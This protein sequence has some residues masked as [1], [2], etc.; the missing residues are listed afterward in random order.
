MVHYRSLFK[1]LLE[2]DGEEEQA[3]ESTPMEGVR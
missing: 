2:S 3:R 1:Q